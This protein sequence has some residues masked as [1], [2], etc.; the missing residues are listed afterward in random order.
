LYTLHNDL[1]ESY[2][3]VQQ[4]GVSS[5]ILIAAT[6]LYNHLVQPLKALFDPGSD[7]T[8]LQQHCLPAGATP[9][10]SQQQGGML[11]ARKGVVV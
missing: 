2:S 3:L 8:F 4:D 9:L 10:I 7:L 1:H 6:N 11:Y 5:S